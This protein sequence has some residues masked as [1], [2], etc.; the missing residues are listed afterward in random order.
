MTEG[1]DQHAKQDDS[2]CGLLHLRSMH[3]LYNIYDLSIQL[4]FEISCIA[5]KSLDQ[6]AS[7]Q[8]CY[9]F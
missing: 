9:G 7:E 6:Y 2:P 4:D 5:L 3:A 1:W 8:L